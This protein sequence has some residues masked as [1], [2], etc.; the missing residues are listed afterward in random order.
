MSDLFAS[1]GRLAASDLAPGLH[2]ARFSNGMKV[3]IKEDHRTPVAI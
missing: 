1:D 2:T 3:I